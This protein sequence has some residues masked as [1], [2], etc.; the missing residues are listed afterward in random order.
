MLLLSPCSSFSMTSILGGL[1]DDF[2]ASARVVSLAGGVG[3]FFP[4]ILGCLLFPV[5]AKGRSLV[6]LYLIDGIVGSIFTLILIFLPHTPVTFMLALVGEFLFQAIAF[7]IQV[8]IMFETIGKDNPFAATTYTLLSAATYVPITYMMVADGRGYSIGG[9][10]GSL[11]MDAAVSIACCLLFGLLL[12]KLSRHS[13]HAPV[14]VAEM[15][16]SGPL[17]K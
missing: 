1:G 2:H 13:F 7:S 8:G 15:V 11:G 4:G 17:Q 12:Y 9:I 14:S 16:N 6:L 5:I 3:A 10:A